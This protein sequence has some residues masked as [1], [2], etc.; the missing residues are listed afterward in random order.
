MRQPCSQK[1][2]MSW[3]QC[4]LENKSAY[5]G[6]SD[7]T[8]GALMKRKERSKVILNGSQINNKPLRIDVTEPSRTSPNPFMEQNGLI[9]RSVMRDKDKRHTSRNG[10][11]AEPSSIHPHHAVHETRRAVDGKC[12]MCCG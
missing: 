7:I 4:R 2:I 8:T 10:I 12:E 1:F 5:K 9:T 6:M 3:E 11:C